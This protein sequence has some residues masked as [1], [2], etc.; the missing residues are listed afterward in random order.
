[1]ILSLAIPSERPVQHRASGPS[2]GRISLNRIAAHCESRRE[3]R[4]T[5][6]MMTLVLCA[7]AILGMSIC[8]F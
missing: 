1:M 2:D 8:Y 4:A 7:A 6:S 3:R 5:T